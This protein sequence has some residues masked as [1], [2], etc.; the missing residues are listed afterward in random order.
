M[1]STQ[2]KQAANRIRLAVLFGG[3]STEHE[4]SRV[5]AHSIICNLDPAKY[6]VI[7]IGISHSGDW[8]PYRGDVE[9]LPDGSWEAEARAALGIPDQKGPCRMEEGLKAVQSCDCVLPVLHGQNGEDGTIQGLLE[10]LNL[11]YVGC[12]VFASAAGMDK[13]YAKVLFAGA[14][15]PQCRHL[16]AYRNEILRD[17]HAYE[18]ETASILGYPCFVKPS[19]SGSSVGVR[20]VKDPAELHDALT[21]AQQFDRKVLIEEFVDGREIECA[22]LGND[23]A[24]AAHPGEIVPSKEF[25]DYEDKYKSGASYCVIPAE[26]P[27]AAAEQIRTYALRAFHAIDGSGLSRVDFFYKKDGTILLNEINTLPGFAEISMYSKLWIAAGM[28]YGGLLDRLIELAFE[29]KK[30]VQRCSHE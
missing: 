12:N 4:V 26:I 30:D 3:N 14:G 21:E 13:V 18:A 10:L 23:E 24:I 2:Q 1:N 20:K 27:Q 16:V 6:E 7:M 15:I 25:Y 5:S 9:K 22:V 11:P 28:T 17:P 19:N 29:R 8:L